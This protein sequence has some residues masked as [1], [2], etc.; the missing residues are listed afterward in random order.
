[1]NDLEERIRNLPRPAPSRALDERIAELLSPPREKAGP[2]RVLG[3][4]LVATALA[5]GLAGFAAGVGTGQWIS[6]PPS[7]QSRTS[8]PGTSEAPG[9]LVQI[10]DARISAG[11]DFSQSLEPFRVQPVDQEGS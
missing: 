5:A 3:R 8:S 1:M 6:G 11:L 4:L 2:P 10:T 7:E 9:T